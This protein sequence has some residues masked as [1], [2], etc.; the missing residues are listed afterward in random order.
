VIDEVLSYGPDAANVLFQ[1]VT[2]RYLN[3]RPMIFTTN[4]AADGLGPVL[5]D[6]DLAE[7]ILDRI[8]ERGATWTSAG[9]PTAP[10]I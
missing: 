8:L 4:K 5:H 2:D 6:P 1:V 9:R 10:S 7:A 3:R